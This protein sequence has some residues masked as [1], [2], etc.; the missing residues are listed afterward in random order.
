MQYLVICVVLVLTGCVTQPTVWIDTEVTAEGAKAV[1]GEIKW[2]EYYATVYKKYAVI[3]DE[4]KKEYLLAATL[5]MRDAAIAMEKGGMTKQDFHGFQVGIGS[6]TDEALKRPTDQY[7][8]EYLN[9]FGQ[10]L[11]SQKMRI[12]LW[13]KGESMSLVT[14]PELCYV[15]SK[16]GISTPDKQVAIL[17][18]KRR[19]VDCEKHRTAIGAIGLT[20]A[21]KKFLE[22]MEIDNSSH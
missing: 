12:A 2:S 8:A 4:P 6:A 21:R 7:T 22:S 5:I 19:G 11:L 13:K 17:D 16:E 10:Y 20:H 9:E 14:D 1:L 15:A 18:I 3:P